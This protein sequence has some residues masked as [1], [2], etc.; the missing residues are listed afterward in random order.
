M[1]SLYLPIRLGRS[2]GLSFKAPKGSEQIVD[3]TNSGKRVRRQ[4]EHWK[5]RSMTIVR[6]IRV[7]PKPNGVTLLTYRLGRSS[8]LSFKTPKGSER[9]VDS[10]NSGKSA[11]TG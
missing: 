9:K 1:V 8:G 7:N 3:G 5:L 11:Q 4:A 10:T 2:S 6:P